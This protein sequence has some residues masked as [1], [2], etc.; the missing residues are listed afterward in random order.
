MILLL[1]NN[2][3]ESIRSV[4]GDRYII[5]DETKKILYIDANMLYGHSLSQQLP[6]DEIEF[7]RKVNLGDIINTPDDS[8]LGSFVEVDIKYPDENNEK[9]KNFPF[10][11]EI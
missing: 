7:D 4:K 3:E 11:P 8:D 1:E 6:Y 9:T 10:A 5:S 2:V